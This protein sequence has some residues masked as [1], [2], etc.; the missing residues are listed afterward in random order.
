MLCSEDCGDATYV[1][2]YDHDVTEL[3]RDWDNKQPRPLD[4]YPKN[5]DVGNDSSMGSAQLLQQSV[6]LLSLG[7]NKGSMISSHHRSR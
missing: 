5:H 3:V 2:T 1:R 6:V 4:P 7:S